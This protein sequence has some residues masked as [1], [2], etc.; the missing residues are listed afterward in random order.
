[1]ADGDDFNGKVISE[2]RANDGKVG[3]FFE[4]Q[5]L[6]LLHHA[7]AKTGAERVNPLVYP[8]VGSGDATFA[9]A[10]GP[11]PYPQWL[12]NLCA[13]PDVTIE[14]GTSTVGARARVAAGDER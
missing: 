7:G 14:V 4:G 12:P 8:Q 3:G 13:G 11:P 5:P 2:F 1:M 6:L 10:G 9:T